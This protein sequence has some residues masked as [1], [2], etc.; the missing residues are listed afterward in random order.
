[1]LSNLE[2][3]LILSTIAFT[4]NFYHDN[5]PLKQ[6][7][8]YHKY[9][10]TMGIIVVGITACLAVRTN[11]I[12]GVGFL[13]SINNMVQ[14][15]VMPATYTTHQQQD[16]Q[17][18]PQQRRFKRSV[19]ESKKKIVAARQHWKCAN[20]NNELS[21]TFEVDHIKRLDRGGSNDLSNLAAICPNCHREKTVYENL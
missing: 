6:I 14:G 3:I 7:M 4:Y 1:M 19:S 15:N 10:K 13:Q 8:S 5:K 12:Q 11:P 18:P 16:P 17:Q 2:W 21:F 20:C 9:Y